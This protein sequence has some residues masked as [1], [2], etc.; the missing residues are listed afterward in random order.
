LALG[1]ATFLYNGGNMRFI[2]NDCLTEKDKS[3]IL[4]GQEDIPDKEYEQQLLN[5][6]RE[7]IKTLKKRDQHFFNCLSWMI[8]SDRLQIIAVKP[9]KNKVGIV[10]H[11]FGIFSDVS[12]N[13]VIFN[14][15]VNFSQF[16]LERNVES[17]WAECSWLVSGMTEMRINDTLQLFETTWKGESTVARIIPIEEVKTEISRL[18]PKKTIQVLIEDEKQLISEAIEEQKVSGSNS[19]SLKKILETIP[20]F[21]TSN[22]LEQNSP[23]PK[24]RDYQNAAIEEWKKNDYRGIFEMATGTGK[25]FTA[26]G[27][28]SKLK[29][30]KERLFVIISCPFI[31]LAEQW[32]YEAIKFGLDS[33]LVGESKSLWEDNAMRQAQLFRRKKIDL[34]V[35]ITTN[36]SFSSESFQKIIDQ[37]LEET[38][39]VIDEVHYAGAKNI[40]SF[41]PDRCS[42]RLGL[43]ATPER[44]GDEEGTFHLFNYFGPIVFSLPIEDAIGKYLTGYY[45]H[46]IPVELTKEE[47]EEY[48]RLTNQIIRL[49]GKKDEQ[50]RKRREQLLIRRARVQNNSINKLEWLRKNLSKLPLDYSLFYAGDQIFND[51]KMILGKELK[52][53]IHEFTSRQDLSERRKLLIDFQQQKIQSLIAMK[54]LDEGVDVPPTRVA[55]FLA[56]S[57]NPKEFIQRRGRVLRESPGKD[58]AIIY[59]LISLPPVQFIENGRAGKEFSAV[60]SAFSKEYK[61]VREFSRMAK[62]RFD[63]IDELFAMANK[64]DLLDL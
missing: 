18:F 13:R 49:I 60:K 58:Y 35:L 3:A 38:L 21:E 32:Q 10:H 41:L 43:S 22:D 20:S 12:G 27:A 46:P 14:G 7:L 26:L 19:T 15:S 5:D 34:V 8:A 33:I 28:I 36:A 9:R 63:S 54:C 6:F 62:N 56:S 4:Q 59:D 53:K 47:F 64:L 52:V 45:Y 29:K 40:R 44:H 17:L 25:T 48:L 30:E 16:A 55:Y 50:N 11:K 2:I 51:V 57:S 37:S 31:H 23:N 42:Y 24:L 61:R 1:F 39:L